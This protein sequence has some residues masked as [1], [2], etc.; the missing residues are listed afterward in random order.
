MSALQGIRLPRRAALNERTFLSRSSVS[1]YPLVV[2]DDYQDDATSLLFFLDDLAKPECATNA[3]VR[4]FLCLHFFGL[5]DMD[6]EVSYR[7]CASQCKDIRDNICMDD[8]KSLA[9]F[10][11]LPN[12][13]DPELFDNTSLICD[14]QEIQTGPGII[15]V[16]LSVIHVF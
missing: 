13:D 7:P 2:T 4:P 15:L 14:K 6:T 10:V 16:A 11:S 12:C 1:E 3:E 9:F 8:W 5:C